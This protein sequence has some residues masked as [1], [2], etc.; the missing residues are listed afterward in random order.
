MHIE[1]NDIRIRPLTEDDYPLLLKW[2]T[3]ERVL[4]FYG[5]RDLAYTPQTLKA[6]YEEPFD[7]EGYRVIVEYRDIPIG[8]GQIYLVSE[9]F[10]RDYH[11][12]DTTRTVYAMDQFIGEVAYW[13]RGIGTRYI[14]MVCAYLRE[15]KHVDAVILD[16]HKDNA[17]AIRAYQK[18]G[19]SVIGEL[20]EH[21]L[22]EGKYVDC[23]L[24]ERTL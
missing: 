17:R 4:A 19:F 5:G 13:N 14:G 1:D 7:A 8:Y 24:M 2:L 15:E 6:H 23:Y 10:C 12:P 18:A 22:F 21:E 16:P 9:A 3:D 11:Y 20:P